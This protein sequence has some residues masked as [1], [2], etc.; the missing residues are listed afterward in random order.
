M[1]ERNHQIPLEIREAFLEEVT[2]QKD[3]QEI[4]GGKVGVLQARGKEG[5]R[6]GEKGGG[7]GRAR[8]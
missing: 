1:Q 3:E 6:A 5:T 8:A 4:T 7:Q 2:R